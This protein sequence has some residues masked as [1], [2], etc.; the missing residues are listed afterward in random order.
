MSRTSHLLYLSLIAL[1]IAPAAHAER[2]EITGELT[3][4]TCAVQ[5]TGGAITVPMGKVDLVSVNAATRAGQKNF[6]I[7]LDCSGSG[8]S[9]DVG[10]RFGGMPHASTGNLALTAASTATNVGVALY[11]ASGAHQRLGDEPTQW[12]TIAAGASGQLDYSA[13]YASPGQNATAG[14]AN[15]SGDFVV[16]YK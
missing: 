2:L 14:S 3:T 13:W 5:S 8:A 11:D 10:V 7:Q 6:S 12:L 1:A 16:L 9:Q 15:A 4:S